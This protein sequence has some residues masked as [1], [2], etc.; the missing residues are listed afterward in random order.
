M[1]II[2]LVGGAGYEWHLYAQMQQRVGEQKAE[3]AKREARREAALQA[4]RRAELEAKAQA[5]REGEAAEQRRNEALKVR[6]KRMVEDIA[7]LYA[8]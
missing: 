7:R 5:C 8:S 6:A 2:L 3:V 1:L 4:R